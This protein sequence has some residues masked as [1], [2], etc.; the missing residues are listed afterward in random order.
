MQMALTPEQAAFD[1]EVR[2]FLAE[3]LPAEISE[4][5]K[6]GRAVGKEICSVPGPGR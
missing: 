2:G 1:Q 5:V 6:L 3:T 4:R